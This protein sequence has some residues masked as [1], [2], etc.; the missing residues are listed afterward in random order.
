[1]QRTCPWSAETRRTRDH[2]RHR[3][4]YSLLCSLHSFNS[5]KVQFP[6]GA[7]A[8]GSAG[9]VREPGA[10]SHTPPARREK[11]QAAGGAG[12]R[13]AELCGAAGRT[14][15]GRQCAFVYVARSAA[16]NMHL[17]SAR[18][19]ARQRPTVQSP[20]RRAPR[21]PGPRSLWYISDLTSRLGLIL[22]WE[23][24]CVHLGS[25]LGWFLNFF[26]S[27]RSV[28]SATQV[29]ETRGDA[30][31][32]LPPGPESSHVGRVQQKLEWKRTLA[33]ARYL[34]PGPH[35]QTCALLLPNITPTQSLAEVHSNV[36]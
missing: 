34:A 4:T 25:P 17:K 36:P 8:P 31:L 20:S 28:T 26:F 21:T 14:G 29:R 16:A 18:V 1:M 27:E 13:D 22:R 23:R 32:H 6:P 11:R 24:F 2:R 33:W 9:A 15:P 7:G 10:G 5:A 3:R 19:S 35:G 30:M 12:E